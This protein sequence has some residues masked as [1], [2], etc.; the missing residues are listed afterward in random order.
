MLGGGIDANLVTSNSEAG[1]DVLDELAAVAVDLFDEDDL[2]RAARLELAVDG[3]LDRRRA[4]D[5][6]AAGA[7]LLGRLGGWR[8]GCARKGPGRTSLRGGPGGGGGGGGRSVAVAVLKEAL[9]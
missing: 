2:A 7:L 4:L 3:Q 8:R 1:L 6:V 5:Q 9:W